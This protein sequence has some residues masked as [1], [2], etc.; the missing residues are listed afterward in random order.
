[1]ANQP[2]AGRV[3]SVALHLDRTGILMVSDNPDGMPAETVT[4]RVVVGEPV[5]RRVLKWGVIVL[6][7]LA[8]LAGAALL[9][10]NTGPGRAFVARQISAMTMASGLN[11]RVGRIDGSIYGAMVLRDVEVR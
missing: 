5:W 10:V 2:P 4:E 11:I 3:E 7:T 8:L 9:A 1:H 6:V